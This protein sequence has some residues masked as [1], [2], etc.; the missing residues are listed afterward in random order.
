MGLTDHERRVVLA[1]GQT[2]FPRD[3]VLGIDADDAAVVPWVE[4]YLDRM[5]PL[6]RTQ[7][8]ALI[9]TFDYAYA[10]WSGRPRDT[11]VA[12]RPDD[13][14]RYL[15]SWE[16]STLYTQ[17]MLYEAIRAMLTFGYVDSPRVDAAIR[18]PEDASHRAAREA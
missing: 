11:F 6:G 17:R 2:M 16:R 4:E 8:R 12:A 13:R 7:I 14:A 5:P 10:A 18:P 9:N 1:I 15:E 3:A